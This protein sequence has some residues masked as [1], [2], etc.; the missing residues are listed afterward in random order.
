M[1]SPTYSAVAR[2]DSDAL[3]RLV[4]AL[5]TRGFACLHLDDVSLHEKLQAALGE[6]SRLDGFRFPPIDSTHP[7]YSSVQKQAFEALYKIA[8][9]V[10]ESVLGTTSGPEGLRRA[11]AQRREAPQPL[12]QR[13]DEP[14]VVGQPFSQS[15]FNLFNYDSGLLNPHADRSLLTVIKVRAGRHASDQQSALWVCDGQGLWR[16]ADAAVGENEVILLVGEDLASLPI[17]QDLG[18]FAA[19]HAVRVDPKGAYV[20]HSHFR[21]DPDT[22]SD[23]NRVSAAFILRHEE[24]PSL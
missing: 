2:G 23:G 11:L 1:S 9:T 6:A 17:A 14:F 20:S 15:F 21:P 3:G 13:D 4:D 8:T 5:R 10:L 18:V 7:D 24:E 22:P 16:N 12:F 19:E